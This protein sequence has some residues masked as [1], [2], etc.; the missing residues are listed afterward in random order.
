MAVCETAAR[1]FRP[2]ERVRLQ[3]QERRRPQAWQLP[4]LSLRHIL[5]AACQHDHS[6]AR[7]NGRIEKLHLQNWPYAAW[8][9]QRDHIAG[10]GYG[11]L[12][13]APTKSG[14]AETQLCLVGS[15]ISTHGCQR[16]RW[17]LCPQNPRDSQKE[18]QRYFTVLVPVAQLLQIHCHPAKIKWLYRLTHTAPESCNNRVMQLFRLIL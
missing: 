3:A 7:T 13:G 1:A 15:V 6:R 2:S 11:G 9:R 4:T 16:F 12:V 14:G 8:S 17:H 10:S 5:S 18:G